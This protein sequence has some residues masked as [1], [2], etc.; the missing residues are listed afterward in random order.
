MSHT[1]ALL[2]VV[3]GEFL[4]AGAK[5]DI[6]RKF[7]SLGVE[8]IAKSDLLPGFS[9]VANEKTMNAKEIKEIQK[10][11]LSISKK[12]YKKLGGVSKYG[13]EKG[14]LKDYDALKVSIKIPKK[15]KMP[16]VD[17]CG[18]AK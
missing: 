12:E 16:R 18:E 14:S 13:F 8:I 5:E 1:N 2:S 9:I 10:A 7:E 11:I 3:K 4:I 6:A 15:S 17:K